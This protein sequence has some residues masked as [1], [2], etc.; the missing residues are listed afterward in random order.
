MQRF[1]NKVILVTGAAAGMGRATCL[2]L[3]SEGASIYG[4]DV[5]E[6]GLA[7]TKQMIVSSGGQMTMAVL[8]VSCRDQCFDAVAN[9][10]N[11]YGRL[12]VLV[13]VAGIIRF[14]HSHEMSEEIWNS[15]IGINL[16][17]PVFLS[18]A[19]IP[20]LLEVEG[21]IVNVASAAGIM[22][23][24]YTMAYCASKA[25]LIQATKSMAMEYIKQS[26]RINVICPGGTD[27]DMVTGVEFPEG[28]DFQ[29][30]QRYV[31]VRGVAQAEDIASAIAYM[32]SDEAKMVHGAVLA[33]DNGALAG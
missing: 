24:A 33:V 1:A 14:C 32:A 30:L 15:I 23:Q 12:D 18:Q 8:D 27:T 4:I 2:R 20:H 9:T 28:I 25:G 10:I 5:N 16:S 21:N 19:A 17:G 26:I 13:N 11:D 3:A 6:A 7:D 31:G 22:G 29:L